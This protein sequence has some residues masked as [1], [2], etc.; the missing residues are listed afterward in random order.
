[1]PITWLKM[2]LAQAYLFPLYSLSST[3]LL[4]LLSFNLNC[5][6][7]RDKTDLLDLSYC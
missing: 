3:C 4:V 7:V 6:E 1:M 2:S 5:Y